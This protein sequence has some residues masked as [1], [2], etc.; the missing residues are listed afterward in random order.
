V[1]GNCLN[2]LEEISSLLRNDYIERLQG[3]G[4]TAVL[5]GQTQGK[6]AALIDKLI[7]N[8]QAGAEKERL[9][10]HEGQNI[11]RPTPVY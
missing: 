3:N 8:I 11:N 2:N 9:Q 10:L 4:P 7:A 5:K 6:P 1:L